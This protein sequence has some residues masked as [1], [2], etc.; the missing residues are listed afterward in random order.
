MNVN[1]ERLKIFIL[2][3]LLL[4]S[5]IA[6]WKG[7]HKLGIATNVGFITYGLFKLYESIS[8][9]YYSKF[10]LDFLRIIFA[11]LII[12]VALD[13]IA[14]GNSSSIVFPLI[15]FFEGPTFK[16]MAGSRRSVN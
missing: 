12:L 5:S 2:L 10:N 15:L 14:Q 11:I 4:L 7:L 1:N 3:S 8:N 13:N 6:H 16:R 9:K